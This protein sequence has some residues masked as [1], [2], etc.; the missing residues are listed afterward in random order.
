MVSSILFL[1]SKV[2]GAAS[3]TQSDKRIQN[4]SMSVAFYASFTNRPHASPEVGKDLSIAKA[5]VIS[6]VQDVRW[7]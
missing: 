5:P 7:R 4:T 2:G 1:D 6:R 3:H